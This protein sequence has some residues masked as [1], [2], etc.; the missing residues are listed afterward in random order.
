M[1]EKRF[2]RIKDIAE[3]VDENPST[4]RYWEQ[5]FDE[6]KPKRGGKGRRLY[7]S[8]D[9]ETIRKIKFLLRTKGMHIAAAKEQLR[10]NNK[11]ISTRSLALTELE[12]LRDELNLLLKSMSKL[13]P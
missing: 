10:K 13:K 4:L 3:F 5:E 12:E 8:A 6:L 9:L 11:N 7:T 2:F 1:E